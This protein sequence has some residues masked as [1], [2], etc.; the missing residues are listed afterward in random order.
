MLRGFFR[1]DRTGGTGF[2]VVNTVGADVTPDGG[3]QRQST[4][5]TRARARELL[6]GGDRRPDM[7]MEVLDVAHWRAEANVATG[8]PRGACSSP[9]TPRTSSRPTAASAATPASR[10]RTTSPGSSR[11]SSR[12][13]PAPALLD[14]YDA[15]R[16]PLGRLTVEQAYTRYATRRRPRARHR[17]REPLDRRPHDGD[18]HAWCARARSSPSPATTAPARAPPRVARAARHARA[19]RRARPTAARRST[20][21]GAGSSCSAGARRRRRLGAAGRHDARDRRRRLRR[22]LRHR[23]GG[24][25]ARATGRH[26]RMAVGA[27]AGCGRGGRGAGPRALAVA[28][29]SRAVAGRDTNIGAKRARELRAELGL[30]PEEPVGSLLEARRGAAP[31][32]GRRGVAPRRHRRVLLARRRAHGAVGQRHAPAGAHALH[33]RARGWPRPLRPRRRGRRSTP[34]RRSPAAARTPGRCRP[35][36]SRRSCW[37]RPRASGPCSTASRPSRTSCGSP[38]GPGSP[39]RG[40]LPPQHPATLPPGRRAAPGDRRRPRDGRLAAARPAAVRRRDRGDRPRRP[41]APVARHRRWR[42]RGDRCRADLD[43]GRRERR[44]LR[45][46]SDS[47]AAQ[48][49]SASS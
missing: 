22:G 41:A 37:R 28:L 27:D 46:A 34:P 15:E 25:V 48:R 12:A 36:R 9:A 24:R 14:T 38:R 2:L 42:A 5:S 33:A 13:T 11:R 6:R 19:A 45:A 35:T 26:R 30:A 7:P 49:R 31:A 3:G 39:A 4:G 10:T 1:L 18:R 40:A 8:S 29:R 17:R 16:R 21:S 23:P 43:R 32:S 44:G 20:C 47:P